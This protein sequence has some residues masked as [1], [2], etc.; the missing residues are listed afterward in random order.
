LGKTEKFLRKEDPVLAIKLQKERFRKRL[1]IL[2]GS[3]TG[4]F[5]KG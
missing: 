4:I 1:E 2:G 3:K 5:G